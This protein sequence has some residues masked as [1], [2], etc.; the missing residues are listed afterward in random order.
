VYVGFLL[1]ML[2]LKI[3][4]SPRSSI[5]CRGLFNIFV[6][7]EACFVTDYMVNFGED[8]FRC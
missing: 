3:T 7:V 4:L 8:T 1:F 2:L 5:G 6:C